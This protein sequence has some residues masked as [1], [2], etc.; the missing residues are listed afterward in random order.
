MADILIEQYSSVL[1]VP[2]EEVSSE[3]VNKLISDGDT[4]KEMNSIEVN[5]VVVREAIAEISNVAASGPYGV[6]PVLLKNG[7]NIIVTELVKLLQQSVNDGSFP[8]ELKDP[9]ICPIWKG[10]SRA[11][12]VNYRPV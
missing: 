6:S 1:R 5:P 12:P 2:R 4:E 10:D 3:F 11:L 9:W 7:G 8:E